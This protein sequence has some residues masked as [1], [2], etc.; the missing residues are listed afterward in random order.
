MNR[1]VYLE[2]ELGNKFGKEFTMN[3]NSF[4]DVFR[5]LECN[6][7]EIRQYLIEC[8]EKNVGFVCEVAGIPLESEK[9]LLLQY[10]TGDM[11]ITPL[12]AGSKS[13]GG[14][15]TG[16]RSCARRNYL[17]AGQYRGSRAQ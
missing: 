12:P 4:S 13:G 5:C 17:S 11:V 3:A 2:G 14:I 7:P 6:Y 9:E 10:S 1:K 16:K 15:F 8:D